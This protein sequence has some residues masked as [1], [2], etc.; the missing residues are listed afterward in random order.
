MKNKKVLQLTTLI[1]FL[2]GIFMGA[3]DTGIVSPARTIIQSN[4][5]I[6]DSNGVWIITI[7]T[8]VYAVSMP[9]VSKFSDIYGRKRVYLLSIVIFGIGSFLC[10]LSSFFSSFEFLL[11]ARVIQAVGGGGIMPIAT[12]YIGQCFPDE[13]KGRALGYVG[14]VYGVATMLGPTIGSLVLS[15]SGNNNWGWIFFVNI[16]ITIIILL[17]GL[18][19]NEN[20]SKNIVKVD[21]LGSVLISVVI[22]SLMYALNNLNF[23]DFG[24]SI[25]NINVYPYL[26]IFLVSLPIFVYIEKRASDPVINLKYFNNREISITFLIGLI[27]GC[28][29]M[30]TI[31]IPQFAENILGI[32]MGSG[33]YLVTLMSVFS[34]IAA[35]VGGKLVDKY[36]SKL[37]LA[38]GFV[39]TITGALV[40][41]FICTK[42]MNF[43]SVFLGLALAGLGIG[44]TMGTPLNYIILTSVSNDESASAL[45]TLSLIRSIG[46]TIFPNIMINFIAKAGNSV[47]EKIQEVIPSIKA[48]SLP[49]SV[50]VLGKSPDMNI[51]SSIDTNMISKFKEADVTTIFDTVK[52]FMSSLIDKIS[53]GIHN[54]AIGSMKSALNGNPYANKIIEKSSNEITNSLSLWKTSYMEGLVNEKAKIV[55]IFQNTL[56]LGFKEMFITSS[57]IALIGLIL[58]LML[59]NKKAK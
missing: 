22:L 37:V 44:F 3:V 59:E 6:N 4:L 15:V 2:L 31:F 47:P 51:A 28:T 54:G 16:P 57:I 45:S 17:L 14:A 53:I 29:L 21:V 35:P 50:G 20:K 42:Y 40:L 32:K 26:L 24:N 7:Y 36:S 5:G 8:L 13:K 56:N 33:G 11:V 43:P 41:A 55:S 1:V 46:I 58:T 34:G 25:R 52:E 39:M 38:F 10:G 49:S 19:L 12:A 9:I 27:T 18:R 48:P 23:F 30:S